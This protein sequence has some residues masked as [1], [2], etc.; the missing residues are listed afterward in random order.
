MKRRILTTA[1]IFHYCLSYGQLFTA[2]TA[3]PV[4]TT[5]GDSRSVNFTD[6]N[7]DGW[8]DIFITNGPSAFGVSFL[9]LNN[10]D[11][12]FTKVSGDDIVTTIAPY[13]GATI[14]DA[15]NDGDPDVLAVTWYD[16]VDYYFVN[17]GDGTFVKAGNNAL[18][19]SN[20]YS[21]TAS[22]GDY[23]NDGWL[24]A[25]VSNSE[26]DFH[27]FLFHNNGDG[28]FTKITAGVV[29]NDAQTSRGVTWADY[30]N[31][32]DPDI[33][34]VNESSEENNL[35]RNDDGMFTK[36]TNGP[37]VSDNRS[38]M[39][40]SWGDIDN[41]GDLDVYTAN[42]GFFATQKNQ[43]YINDGAGNF[44]EISSGDAVSD[45]GCSFSSSFADYDNDGDL[46]LAV[47]NGFC[48]GTILNFLYLN[49]GNGVFERDLNSI[50][51]LTTPCSY[52]CAWG[53]ANNDGFMDLV[54][55]TCKNSGVGTNPPDLFYMNNGNGNNWIK[56]ELAGTQSN[57]SAIGA[58]VKVKATINGNSVWQMREITAQSGYCSQN[59]LTA[60]F[61]LGD[62]TVIDSVRVHFPAGNDTVL[63]N[64][65]VNQ[66]IEVTEAALTGVPGVS[67]VTA[68]ASCFP[69]PAHDIF[70]IRL[71]RHLLNEEK[72]VRLYNM[73]GFLVS[74]KN[75][76]AGTAVLKYT[77]WLA[78][79]LYMVEVATIH[80]KQHLKLLVE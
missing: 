59:S 66:Q 8:D 12:S 13:D 16:K 20:G 9:Y 69:N 29:V 62:A 71:S 48:N 55:A 78:A 38:T 37:L 6:L 72:T 49:D 68:S 17:N 67:A 32:G 46:D 73:A 44:T 15:D 79:G 53:D 26:G 36:I 58:R 64:V 42:S 18:G 5:G 63:I 34:V 24:D 10:G 80:E 50:D 43:L 41:D 27:N 4:V 54:F 14:A 70:Y 74:K 23:D 57:K 76:P 22:W 75:F 60:H 31:D 19:T 51:D 56:I 52:G 11:G 77:E 61:G 33:Y 30:D 65:P 40:A 2:V 39:S 7:N 35:Y 45:G 3:G 28:S 25:Y 1:I 47:S 21:E